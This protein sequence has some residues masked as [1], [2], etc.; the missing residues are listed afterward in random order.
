MLAYTDSVA[1]AQKRVTA[2]V[3]EIANA[4]NLQNVIK[5]FYNTIAGIT[6]HLTAFGLMLTAIFATSNL[7]KTGSTIFNVLSTLGMK[8]MSTGF[9]GLGIGKSSFSE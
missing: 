8:T 5:M 9:S 4:E 7:S 6:E 3:E 2:A 1:A